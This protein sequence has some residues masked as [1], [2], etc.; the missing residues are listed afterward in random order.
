MNLADVFTVLLV[1][2]GL[3][4]LFVGLWLATAGLFPAL[5]DRCS[6]RIGTSPLKS[7][8]VGL[9]CLVPLLIGGTVL[10]RVLPNAPGKIASGAIIIAAI[11]VALMGTAGLAVRIGRGLPAARDG[12]EPWRGVLRGSV[13]LALTYLSIVLL[14]LTLVAGF[15]AFVLAVATRGTAATPGGAPRT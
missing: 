11:L 6:D 9:V 3:L 7:G 15:G 5:V 2:L 1:I 10:G 4:T 13:V 12:Q 14:P 8:F